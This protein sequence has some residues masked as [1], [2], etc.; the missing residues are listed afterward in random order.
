MAYNRL[1]TH[2]TMNGHTTNSR[3]M[4][5]RTHMTATDMRAWL[6]VLCWTQKK[7]DTEESRIFKR[8]LKPG[9]P[10]T[11]LNPVEMKDTCP[12]RHRNMGRWP[13]G[14]KPNHQPPTTTAEWRGKGNLQAKNPDRSRKGAAYEWRI[15]GSHT[16]LTNGRTSNS[17]K[18]WCRI[19]MSVTDM[20]AWLFGLCRTQKKKK[21]TEKSRIFKIQWKPGFP[22]RHFGINY[23]SKWRT[24]APQGIEIWAGDPRGI[25]LTTNYHSRVER[26]RKTPSKKP[27]PKSEGSNLYGV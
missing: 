19:H 5:C 6:F 7:K 15:I 17:R 9:F 21:D 10:E 25:N 2:L 4:W 23:Q 11:L 3:K 1:P 16:H 8:E 24:A 14:H 20:R 13:T 18:M 27:W 22:W 12:A 26:R